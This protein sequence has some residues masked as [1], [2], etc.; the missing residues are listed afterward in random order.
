MEPKEARLPDD[1]R[2]DALE[3]LLRRSR[4]AGFDTLFNAVRDFLGEVGWGGWSDPAD[5]FALRRRILFVHQSLTSIEHMEVRA[6]QL[7]EAHYRLW[8][9]RAN[10][11]PPECPA[12]H[13]ALDGI[14]LPPAHPFWQLWD[15]PNGWVCRCAIRGADSEAGAYRKGGDPDKPLPDWWADPGEALPPDFH[16][17]NR[18]DLRA[19]VAKALAEPMC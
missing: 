14:V 17:R 6:A 8:I 9:Y 2:W 7:R 13:Y 19:I 10:A 15:P 4:N 1:G 3:D 5:K 12:R 16:G 18:P 11:G